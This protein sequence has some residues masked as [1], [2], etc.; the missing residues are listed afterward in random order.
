MTITQAN[1]RTA[2][3]WALPMLLGLVFVACQGGNSANHKPDPE[4]LELNNSAV[5]A[6]DDHDLERALELADK[7]IAADGQFCGA[8]A[9]RGAIL[10]ALGRDKEAIL[11]FRRA[12]TLN[13]TFA[14]AY[15]PL[16]ALYEKQGRTPYAK[17]HYAMAV[18][19]YRDIFQK[20]P[21]DAGVAANLSVALF[22][23]DDRNG[24][25]E[26]LTAYL[27][28]HPEDE[29]LLKIKSKIEAKD[30]NGFTGR[31]SGKQ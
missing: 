23:N 20:Q 4:A 1:M 5:K 11:A 12:I 29:T 7:A 16:G 30:R 14:E 2:A 6:L 9:N 27:A 3:M 18:Q 28:R 22:L 25:L 15:V 17:K 8:Y 21:E 24:A 19:L 26:C 10:K 31:E 13:P